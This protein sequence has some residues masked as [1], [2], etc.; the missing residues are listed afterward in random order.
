[1]TLMRA[2]SMSGHADAFFSL[3][4]KVFDV[5]VDLT[6][7]DVVPTAISQARDRIPPHQIPMRCPLRQGDHC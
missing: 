2:L 6:Q 4:P 5:L 3:L 1:M 7:L